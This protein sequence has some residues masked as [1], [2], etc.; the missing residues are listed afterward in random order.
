MADPNNAGPIDV[1]PT[2]PIPAGGDFTVMFNDVRAGPRDKEGYLR[3]LFGNKDGMDYLFVVNSSDQLLK[4][5]AS[6]DTTFIPPATSQ[7]LDAG[8]YNKVTVENV[9]AQSVNNTEEDTLKILTGNGDRT[10]EGNDGFT[11]S[12]RNAVSDLIPGVE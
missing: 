6:G 1:S 4:V 11:F 12:P 7:N 10:T 8:I 5:I 3:K 9:G 2:D